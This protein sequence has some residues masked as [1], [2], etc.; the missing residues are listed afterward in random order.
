M[1]LAPCQMRQ[2]QIVDIVQ[3]NHVPSMIAFPHCTMQPW[4]SYNLHRRTHNAQHPRLKSLHAEN[5]NFSCLRCFLLVLVSYSQQRDSTSNAGD[6][7]S[8]SP[9]GTMLDHSLKF[10]QHA[11]RGVSAFLKRR[12]FS[13]VFLHSGKLFLS[14]HRHTFR[15][16]W[17]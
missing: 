3:S 16:E 1:L 14:C 11:R 8:G 4:V 6:T 2:V 5:S 13:A 17:A 9:S 10:P 15:L 7:R 12:A